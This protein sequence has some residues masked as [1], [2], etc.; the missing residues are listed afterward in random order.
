MGPAVEITFSFMTSSRSPRN[1]NCRSKDDKL[2]SG[3]YH[4][5]SMTRL[6][7]LWDSSTRHVHFKMT[8]L[9]LKERLGED[10]VIL[11]H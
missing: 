6:H 3:A 8:H 7:L 4:N 10:D 2:I 5:Q 1:A 11:A 9:T